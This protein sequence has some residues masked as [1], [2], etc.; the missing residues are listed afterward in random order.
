[1]AHPPPALPPSHLS[2]RSRGFSAVEMIIALAI[3]GLVMA[4]ATRQLIEGVSVTL[5]TSRLLE[6]SRSGRNLIGQLG[7]D[8]SAGQTLILYPEFNDRS[9]PLNPD[10][11]GN[12]LVL[13]QVDP[14]GTITR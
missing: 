14:G 12:Y 10:E 5:K 2:R 9:S 1:M 13:H 8:L 6:H 7:H 4:A 11:S 3:I